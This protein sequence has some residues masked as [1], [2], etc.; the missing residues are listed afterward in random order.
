MEAKN[1]LL[2]WLFLSRNP[3][4]RYAITSV[5]IKVLKMQD[6]LEK[7]SGRCEK[8]VYK[9]CT[10]DLLDEQTLYTRPVL[11]T[12]FRLLFQPVAGGNNLLSCSHPEQ[13]RE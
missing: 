10:A 9:K 11:S 6:M 13:R 7:D 3:S 12:G 4:K 2:N 5:G 1:L 8:E